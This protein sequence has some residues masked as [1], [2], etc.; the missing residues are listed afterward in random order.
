MAMEQG[1]GRRAT[2]GWLPLFAMT[3]AGCGHKERI[4]TSPVPPQAHS[5]EPPKTADGPPTATPDLSPSRRLS[6]AADL[7]DH[8]D[9]ERARVELNELLRQEPDNRHAQTLLQSMTADPRQLYGSESYAHQ[10]VGKENLVDVAR[11]YMGDLYQFYGLARF[12]NIAQPSSV[13]PGQT[14][15]IPGRL[16]VAPPAPPRRSRPEATSERPPTSAPPVPVK[17]AV[18]DRAGAQRLRRAG[19]E[20]LS[21]GSADQAVALLT[22]AAALD[23]GNGAIRADLARA[24]RIRSVVGH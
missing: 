15:M 22:Q 3:L 1:W 7:L 17:P 6:L 13:T 24:R 8:G 9:V 12:N 10:L 4:A 16:R 18:V 11:E 5:A 2:A 23:P 19:L 20:R 14:I 21:A